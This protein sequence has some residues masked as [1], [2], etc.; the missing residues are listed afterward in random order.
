MAVQADSPAPYAPTKSVM[1]VI[2]RFRDK[3]MTT[4]FELDTLTR[5]GVTEALAPRV[6]QAL[7]ILDL[8]DEAG[9]PTEAFESLRRV[10]TDAFQETLA[11][12]VRSAYAEVFNFVDPAEHS[13][14]Q[15]TDAFRTYRPSGQRDRMVTLFLGLCRE[16][17]IVEGP[18][19]RVKRELPSNARRREVPRR[20]AAP[21]RRN[22]GGG[23]RNTG[24]SLPPAV[25][26]L[27]DTLPKPDQGWTKQ[28]RDRFMTAFE[29]ILDYTYPLREQLPAAPD[30][31]LEGGQI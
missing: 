19:E 27:L 2:H 5:A 16:A 8:L 7:K 24:G 11:E 13:V 3:G 29:A 26:S 15:V 10:P 20:Q 25:A 14:S 17:G 1:D 23:S 12:V 18:A 22:T 21:A 9:N 6:L 4:P 31:H 28:Q 30:E